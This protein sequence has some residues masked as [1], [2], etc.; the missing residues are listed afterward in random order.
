MKGIKTI[1]KETSTFL[2]IQQGFVKSKINLKSH[3]LLR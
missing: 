3:T 2:L 1:T